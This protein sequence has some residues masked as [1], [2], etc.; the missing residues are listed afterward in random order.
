LVAEKLVMATDRTLVLLFYKTVVD[1]E[2]A[3]VERENA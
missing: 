1:R 2:I 3:V